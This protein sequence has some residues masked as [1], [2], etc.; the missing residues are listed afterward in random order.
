MAKHRKKR[1]KRQKKQYHKSVIID[2]SKQIA[3]LDDLVHKNYFGCAT[4]IEYPQG[5][6]DYCGL[7]EYC[8]VSNFHDLYRL[9]FDLYEIKTTE[10][11][12]GKAKLQLRRA[13]YYFPNIQRTLIYIAKPKH[14]YEY[15]STSLFR[16]S[17]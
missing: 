12:I 6:F 16:V 14:L 5:E 13:R 4:N 15:T 1:R 17:F 9:T 2:E 8:R 7:L 11:G 3:C 10:H